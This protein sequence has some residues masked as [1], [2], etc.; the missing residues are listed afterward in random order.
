MPLQYPSSLEQLEVRSQSGQGT[1]FIIRFPL[2]EHKHMV[3]I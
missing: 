2:N 1:K 3:N